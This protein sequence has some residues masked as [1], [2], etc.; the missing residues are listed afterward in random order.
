MP[1]NVAAK[2]EKSLSG[3]AAALM[4]PALKV[5]KKQKIK[6]QIAE[7]KQKLKKKEKQFDSL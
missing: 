6:N 2:F 7:L 1:K 3:K 4:G 5:S